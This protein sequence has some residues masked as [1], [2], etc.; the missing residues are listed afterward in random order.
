M[1]GEIKFGSRSTPT[2]VPS[3]QQE[4]VHKP[5][6]I[7]LSIQVMYFN[8]HGHDRFAIKVRNVGESSYVR[9]SLS[10]TNQAPAQVVEVKG[11]KAYQPLG[12]I[13]LDEWRLQVKPSRTRSFI[14]TTRTSEAHTYCAA[15]RYMNYEE[16]GICVVGN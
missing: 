11:G 2:P 1:S 8:R 10:G 13:S 14:F 6:S 7:V 16:L 12:G 4:P 15:G 9:I 3:K 5:R